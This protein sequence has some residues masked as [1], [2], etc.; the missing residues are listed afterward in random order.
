MRDQVIEPKTDGVES[1]WKGKRLFIAVFLFFN[2]FINYMD[3]TSLSIAVPVIAKEFHWNSGTVGV[4]LSSFMWTYAACL[5]PWGWMTDRIGTRKV[6][7]LSVSLWSISAMLTGAAVGF[8]TMIAAM[9]LL[10]VGEAASLPTAGKV[11]R[12]WFPAR[13]RGLAT[14]IFNAGTFA[15]PAISAPIVA[16]IVLRNYVLCCLRNELFVD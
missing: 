5:I 3:R 10:G 11:V 6:N 12:Q 2:L 15:G 13:E 1:L 7:G 4:V 16:W 8:G 14:A 9:L